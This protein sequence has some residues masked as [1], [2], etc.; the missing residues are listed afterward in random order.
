MKKINDSKFNEL[1]HY[2]QKPGRYIGKELNCVYK[3]WDDTILKTVICY[4]DLYEVGMSNYSIRILY[5]IINMGKKLLAERLFLPDLDMQESLLNENLEIFSIESRH[6]IKEFDVIGFT[7]QYELNYLPI[8]QILKLANIPLYSSQRNNHPLIMAGGSGLANPEPIADFIDFFFIGEA[9]DLIIQILNDIKKWKDKNQSNDEIL[10]KLN[11]LDYIYVP[12]INKNNVKRHIVPDLNKIH[13]PVK[14]LVP[15]I[16]VVQNRGIIE[17][18]RG[19]INNCRF[20]QAGYYYRPKRE[21]DVNKIKNIAKQLIRNTGYDRITLL[22][23]SI[24]NYS[25]LKSL[26]KLLNTTFYKK[27]I[28]LSL[29]SIRIDRFTINL[30]EEL[31]TV[32]KSGLTFALETADK[33]LQKKINKNINIENFIETLIAVAKKGWKTVKIY[34]MI[35]FNEDFQEIYAIKDLIDRIITQLK[36]NHVHLKINLHVNPVA[37]KPLTPLYLETQVDFEIIEKKL[38]QLRNLFYS[39]YYKRWVNLKGQS[40]NFSLLDTI[41]S[42]AD[43]KMGKILA[44]LIKEGY[45]FDTFKNKFDINRWL[46]SFKKHKLDYKKYIYDKDYIKKTLNSNKLSFNYRDNF[47]KEEYKKY[48]EAENTETCIDNN[49]YNCGICNKKIKNKLSKKSQDNIPTIIKKN[50]QKEKYK[51]KLIFKKKGFYKFISHR[52]LWNVFE[53]IFRIIELPIAF[54]EGFNKRMRISL[55]FPPPLMVEGENEILEFITEKSININKI[56]KNI[57]LIFNDKD[58]SV[59][60]IKNISTQKASLNST[61]NFSEYHIC[62]KTEKT[63]KEFIKSI[64]NNTDIEIIT[65]GQTFIEVKLSRDTSITKTISYLFNKPFPDLWH[66]IQNITR[67]K[68]Y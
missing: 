48:I 29:P 67:I 2:I 40:I 22:S 44:S 45:F 33:N 49:C 14:Q 52:D 17:V 9:D 53:K 59:K 36:Q 13:H 58:F 24:S 20:C 46:N 21:R 54:T 11:K 8:L 47:F 61:L 57:N 35:G 28:S 4:P 30:L 39:K 1:L 60:N 26:L 41:L 51:Y 16:D 3:K 18:D 19:C 15:L 10:I 55:I 38:D 37:K 23:L 63:Q 32:R 6:F 62:F 12:K 25:N 56:I 7:I 31:N 68:I 65:K 50:T 66:K 5:E 27:G 42:R 34:L 64:K 43:R